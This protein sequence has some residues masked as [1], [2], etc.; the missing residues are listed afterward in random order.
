MGCVGKGRSVKSILKKDRKS[1][2]S[3]CEHWMGCMATAMA[4]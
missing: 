4:P 1:S 2:V 3:E